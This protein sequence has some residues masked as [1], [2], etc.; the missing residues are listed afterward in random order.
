MMG[1]PN[2]SILTKIDVLYRP[3]WTKAGTTWKWILTFFKYQNECY[4]QSGKSRYKNGV[5][6]L[7]FMFRSWVMVLKLY[8]CIFCNFV[9]TLGRNLRLL[10]E[11]TYCIWKFSLHSFRKWCLLGSEQTR[12]SKILILQTLISPKQ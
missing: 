12:I 7:V 5:I 3:E 8:K 9:L 6:C 1:C 4:K 2:W 10:K 11:F